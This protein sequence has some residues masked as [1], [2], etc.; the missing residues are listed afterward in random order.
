MYFEINSKRSFKQSIIELNQYRE[1]LYFFAWKDINIKYKQAVLGFMWVILQ[2]V[3]L[4]LIFT[5][6]AQAVN[7]SA[8]EIPYPVFAFSGLVFWGV[9]ASGVQG[10]GNSV[11]VNANVIKKIYFPRIILPISSILVSLFDFLIGL[12]VLTCLMAYYGISV[13]LFPALYFI[14]LAI[15]I[16]VVYS[17]G[18]GIWLAALNVRY[19][20]FKYVIPFM[21]QLLF[22]CSPIVYPTSIVTNSLVKD[23]YYLNPYA[24][25]LDLVRHSLFGSPIDGIHVLISISVAFCIFIL[26]V[27]V[28]SRSEKTFADIA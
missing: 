22:F 10:A 4:M 7:L 2:P 26:G 21:I 23:L 6:F 18:T 27:L 20:D 9:F 15:I 13:N 25:V 3:L 12:L 19:R 5:F 8:G 28:F 17:L 14:P 16:G 24:G 11:V 1:L